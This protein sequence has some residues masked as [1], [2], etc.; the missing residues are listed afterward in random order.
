LGGSIFRDPDELPGLVSTLIKS[1]GDNVGPFIGRHV[2]EAEFYNI[3]IQDLAVFFGGD[4][5]TEI[6]VNTIDHKC[7]I[8]EG[9]LCPV[10]IG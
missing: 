5:S 3:E 8:C 9:D 1:Y 10:V 7:P 4:K 6:A 2:Y